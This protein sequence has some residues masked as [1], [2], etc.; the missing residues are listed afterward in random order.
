M[1]FE[2]FRRAAKS[3]DCT[4]CPENART[5]REGATSIAECVCDDT[6]KEHGGECLCPAGFEI[7]R[8]GGSQY[9]KPPSV[10]PFA[11]P[12]R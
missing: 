8:V 1:R 10:G 2:T 6:F 7:V 4:P 11:Q 3:A 12:T 9:W 5:I